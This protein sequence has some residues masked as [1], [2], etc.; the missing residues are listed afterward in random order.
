MFDSLYMLLI[1][2]PLAE[3]IFLLVFWQ[4]FMTDLLQLKLLS[5]QTWT[6]IFDWYHKFSIVFQSGDWTRYFNRLIFLF[7]D[8]CRI[9][10]LISL[11][12]LSCWN[13]Q[14]CFI[15]KSWSDIRS[16]L[17]NI[18]QF[19]D[20]IHSFFDYMK[21]LHIIWWKAGLYHYHLQASQLEQCSL[22]SILC[23]SSQFDMN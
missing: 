6:Q 11:E 5:W 23:S 10:L 17:L 20:S 19:I 21:L 8:H 3:D 9:V 2:K 16:F 12:S 14:L 7:S 22:S 1:L 15:F 18:S 4:L 13:L